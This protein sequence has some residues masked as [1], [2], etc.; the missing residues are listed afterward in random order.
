MS[1]HAAGAAVGRASVLDGRGGAVPTGHRPRPRR[2]V[3]SGVRRRDHPLHRG[4]LRPL[5]DAVE[6]ATFVSLQQHAT[7]PHGRAWPCPSRLLL[8][9]R[10]G[11]RPSGNQARR[12]GPSVYLPRCSESAR[13]GHSCR[14]GDDDARAVAAVPPGAVAVVQQRRHRAV[15]AGL[16]GAAPGVA[17][18]RTAQWRHGQQ[19]SLARP[20]GMSW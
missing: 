10:N 3:V 20:I 2:R 11:R 13:P 1:R 17:D 4:D 14:S 6:D 12:S 16:P 15:A 19:P 7:G 9:Q 18:R 8:A 5:W